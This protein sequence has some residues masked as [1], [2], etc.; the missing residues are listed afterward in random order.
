MTAASLHSPHWNNAAGFSWKDTVSLRMRIKFQTSGG[1]DGII[2]DLNGAQLKTTRYRII[3]SVLI[4]MF[5]SSDL[6]NTR[7]RM[8]QWVSAHVD[9]LLHYHELTCTFM[10][11]CIVINFF[12]ISKLDALISQIYFGM[13]LYVFRTIPLSIVRSYSLY[14]QQWYT[15]YSFRAGSGWNC[16]SILI[17]LL[18]S[19]L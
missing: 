3:V 7:R 14:A 9:I 1:G 13:K 6:M 16:S 12:T 8:V 2:S 19:C 11:P 17:L 5:F 15:S 10:W 18:E 4:V